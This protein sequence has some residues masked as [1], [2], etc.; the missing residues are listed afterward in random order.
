MDTGFAHSE[1]RA[2]DAEARSKNRGSERRPSSGPAGSG[3]WLGGSGLRFVGGGF[4][5]RHR[6]G[7]GTCASPDRWGSGTCASPVPTLA[8]DEHGP[9]PTFSSSRAAPLPGPAARA[10]VCVSNK[11]HRRGRPTTQVDGTI[12]RACPS[13]SGVG[14]RRANQ[15]EMT[16]QKRKEQR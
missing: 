2:N 11:E 10:H 12:P 15:H 6:W 1:E 3:P 7:S 14:K 8:G 13:S 9:R 5:L 4:G 16:E